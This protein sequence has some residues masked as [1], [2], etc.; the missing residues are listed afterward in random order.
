VKLRDLVVGQ[1][2]AVR[3]NR[4]DP[5]GPSAL[6]LDGADPR[7]VWLYA[8]FRGPMR[9]RLVAAGVPYNAKRRG[10]VVVLRVT[11]DGAALFTLALACVALSWEDYD[12]DQS[13][14]VGDGA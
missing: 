8:P 6:G 10:G 5:V 12:R 13:P 2:Y 7:R 1:E 11:P 14:G 9:A 3:R 4:I